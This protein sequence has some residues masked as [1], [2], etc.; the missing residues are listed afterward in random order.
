MQINIISNPSSY[1]NGLKQQ[2]AFII[3]IIIINECD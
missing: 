3:I 1:S 2:H